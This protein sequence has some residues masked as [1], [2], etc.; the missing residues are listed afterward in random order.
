MEIKIPELSLVLL[1]G[2][3]GSGKSTFAKKHFL[4]TE[5][6]SS[7]KCR[8]IVSNDENSLSA[9]NDAFD[10]L[11]FIIGKRLKNGLLTV[12]D[13]TNVQPEGRKKLVKLAR[14]YHVLPSAI[15]L[16]IPKNVCEERNAN[17]EDR[18]ISNYA[19]RQQAMQ[20]RRSFKGLKREG[21]RKIHLLKSV[22][23]VE[24][25]TGIVREKLYNDRKEITGP[26]D[27][28]GDVH[29]CYDELKELLEKLNY[30]I[31]ETS[32]LER[33]N[34]GFEINAPEDRKVIFLGDLTD[35]GPDSPRVLKLVMTMV[36]MGMAYCVCGNHD[37]K[38]LKWLRGKNVSTTH[39]LESTIQQLENETSDFKRDLREF[40]YSLIS[41]FVFDNG[42]LVV[43]H[44]GIKEEMQ[45]RGSGAV[46]SF[47]MYG[48]TS[49]ELDEYGM[50]ARYNWAADYKGK[51]KVVYGHTAVLEAEWFNRT[52]DIDTG[53]VFGGKLTALRYPEEELVS[54]AAKKMHFEPTKP[55]DIP[56]SNIGLSTQQVYDDLLD[57]EDVTGKRIVQTRL[58][59]N[60]TIREENS[61]AALEVMSRFTVN[62]KW[63]MYLPP[64]MSPCATSDLDGY[65]EH[66][67]EAIH[68][69]KKRGI[70]KIICEEKHMG[71]RAVI[72]ICKDKVTAVK[73]FG[74]KREG[75][76]KCFTRTGRNF[77][78]DTDLEN[79]FLAL[80]Q[81][82]LTKANFWEKFETNWVA[83]DCELMPWSAK[84]QA[85][86]KD[87]YASVGTA[88]KHGLES[89][90]NA[91]SLTKARGIEGVGEML[92]KYSSKAEA[93]GKYTKAYQEYCWE[94]NSIEDYRLAP[95]HILATE[96]SVHI[97][98]SHEWHLENIY[99]IVDASD[100]LFFKTPYKIIDTTSDES[101]QS[102][103]DWWL[104]LTGKGG[105]GMVVK[106]AEFI[107]YGKDGLLQPAIKC[108][109]KEYLRIIYGPDYDH[110]DNLKRLQ[111]RG[112]SR[113][114]SL[115]LREFAL[116][117]ESMERFVRNEP[118]RRVHESVFGV[119]ALESEEVDP[120][121]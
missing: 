81:K 5:I 76:G 8:G 36:N 92:E 21:F 71:S 35:R 55:L 68:Y 116:G 106:P 15:V 41:H 17:R 26:F 25:V 93:I 98:K 72:V 90:V 121:L 13:A 107:A 64:T 16:D 94:V 69:Y 108:R 12:V 56:P 109:G 102:A 18:N 57:I 80:V 74:V 70:E 83:L 7:D 103:I 10:L 46:R 73:R 48:E 58:R 33:G 49:G 117:V 31:T 77:F 4:N 39:G 19:I 84:A 47:C 44:A 6:V 34:Y 97:D 32:V 53:C 88:A 62:P 1:I 118:L 40:L 2:A 51:A 22:E 112:L 24:S 78:N 91:L 110:P 65:L 96:G 30:S 28:I 37:A 59:N 75:I 82:G 79:E 20:L 115:A 9:T 66:P 52:I 89:V 42:K 60:L 14:E 85:L 104:E 86:L 105:E 11:N 111:K 45:G 101:V 50:P 113:K 63:L 23:E 61:I 3:S 27:I 100:A 87:Q 29:G 114:R 119:L 99:Q 54:V 95:F 67:K 120:R 43:A 38:L